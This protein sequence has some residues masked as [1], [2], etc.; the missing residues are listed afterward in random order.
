MRTQGRKNVHG[1]GGVRFK[2]AFTPSKYK[3]MLR[4]LVTELIVNEKVEV[5]LPVAKDLSALAD[6]MVTFGKKGDL[7]ARR[8]A[9]Q[10]LRNV[11]VDKNGTTALKKLFDDI[12]KRYENRNGGYTRVLKTECRRGDNAQM[13]LV[14]FVA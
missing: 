3:A 10:K 2:A 6:K 4:N 1:K 8:L 9:A 13:A 12:A 7:H 5:T 14:S 11:V